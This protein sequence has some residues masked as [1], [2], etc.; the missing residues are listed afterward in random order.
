[1]TSLRRIRIARSLAA[2][3]AAIV[4]AVP[5]AQAS[6]RL[7]PGSGEAPV[8]VETTVIDDGFDWGSAAIGAGGAVLVLL[9]SAAGLTALTGRH[10][11]VGVT[12]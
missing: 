2:G 7:E 8:P 1:M 11:R 9:L 3:L 4:L 10:D 12:R 5:S 6:Q